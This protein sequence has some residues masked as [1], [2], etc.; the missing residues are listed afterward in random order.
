MQVI[1]K[2]RKVMRLSKIFF[3]ES[4]GHYQKNCVND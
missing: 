1:G 3:D 4:M 2:G